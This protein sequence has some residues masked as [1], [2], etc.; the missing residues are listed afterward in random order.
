[1]YGVAFWGTH[2]AGPSQV[3]LAKQEPARQRHVQALDGSTGAFFGK[4]V[5]FKKC[6]VGSFTA[7]FEAGAVGDP[8]KHGSE[9]AA[10]G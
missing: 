4:A 6:R 2:A 1:M 9:C 7:A 10:I 5:A 3:V 8:G